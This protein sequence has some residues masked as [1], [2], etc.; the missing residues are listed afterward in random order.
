MYPQRPPPPLLTI[1]TI[2]IGPSP[3]AESSRPAFCADLVDAIVIEQQ[4]HDLLPLRTVTGSQ[5]ADDHRC[6]DPRHTCRA[7][8]VAR[9]H[10]A[11]YKQTADA[12]DAHHDSNALATPG[13]IGID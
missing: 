2:S 12:R 10:Q 7:A 11:E 3:I 5:P 6:D 9:F 13:A 1:H 8:D 4:S